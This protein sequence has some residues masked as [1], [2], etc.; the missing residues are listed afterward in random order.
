[1]SIS[2][3]IS[4]GVGSIPIVENSRVPV[5]TERPALSGDFLLGT[6]ATCSDGIWTNDPTEFSYQ[7]YRDSREIP[8]AFMSTYLLMILDRGTTISCLVRATNDF[9]SGFQ[10]SDEV[11]IA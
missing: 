8:L 2:A 6:V 10:F 7:W 5:N 1:M 4:A 3:S 11:F 9:G